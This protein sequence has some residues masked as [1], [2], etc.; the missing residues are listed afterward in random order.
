MN[1]EKQI[2]RNWLVFFIVALFLSGLT[3]IPVE[4]ELSFVIDHFPFEGS[5]KSWLEEVLQGLQQTGKD[6]PYLFYGYDWLG[7]AHVVIAMAFIG[8]YRDPVKNKWVI[9]WAMLCC[10]SILPLA[11]IVGSIRGIPW[12]HI[13]IDCS[14]GIL[15]IL[16]LWVVKKW[17][18]HLEE[19]TKH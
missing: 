3:A 2:I 9:E 18:A 8:P 14:F 19:T 10:L 4:R 13:L 6:Y 11:F 7:F 16:P 5:I 15:G 17:I 1:K 12:F